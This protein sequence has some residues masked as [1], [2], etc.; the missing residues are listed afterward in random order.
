M[1]HLSMMKRSKVKYI[2]ETGQWGK[3]EDGTFFQFRK[4]AMFI[5]D[6]GDSPRRIPGFERTLDVGDPVV[7]QSVETEKG[8]SCYWIAHEESLILADQQVENRK[9]YRLV[10]RSED[11]RSHLRS[12]RG[13][14][15]IERELWKGRNL[16]QLRDIFDVDAFYLGRIDGEYRTFQVWDGYGWV[17]IKED[18][19]EVQQMKQQVA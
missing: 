11:K 10:S 8:I 3:L 15:I 6:G 13:K 5:C 2:N 18:I 4:M 12:L 19:R 7:F 17:D 16:R 14:R 1:S 9:M